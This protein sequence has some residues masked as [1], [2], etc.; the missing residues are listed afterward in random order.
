MTTELFI[1]KKKC[2][3][4]VL[5]EKKIAARTQSLGFLSSQILPVLVLWHQRGIILPQTWTPPCQEG[6]ENCVPI[7]KLELTSIVPGLHPS[8]EHS[9]LGIEKKRN[10]KQ[11]N[12]SGGS[13]WLSRQETPLQSSWWF[14]QSRIPASWGPD[15]GRAC[16]HSISDQ[17]AGGTATI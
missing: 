4:I 3:D 10:W 16:L 12:S 13:C 7:S 6:S 17:T 8:P 11:L 9:P 15:E 2:Q 1:D 5:R 14:W